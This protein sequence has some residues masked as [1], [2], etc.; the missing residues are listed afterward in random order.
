MPKVTVVNVDRALMKTAVEQ[1]IEQHH[2]SK[3]A[4][5]KKLGF[6][7]TYFTETLRENKPKNITKANYKYICKVLNV[8]ESTFLV[9]STPKPKP[10]AETKKE[11]VATPTVVQSGLTPEQFNA[12][13]QAISN[14]GDVIGKGLEKISAT[15]SANAVIQ[16]KIYSELSDLSEALGVTKSKPQTE[17]KTA[18][19]IKSQYSNHFGG[20]K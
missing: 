6:A 3:T 14:L 17:T 18:V 12:L 19:S 8:P 10:V 13:L 15:Q 4:F 9:K 16:G 5:S 1:Y 7:S 20:N 11:E 2:T